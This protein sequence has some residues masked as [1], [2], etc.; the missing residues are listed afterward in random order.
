MKKKI[1]K[2]T[3]FA[4]TRTRLQ[5][6][7]PL[8]EKAVTSHKSERLF[9]ESRDNREDRATRQWKTSYGLTQRTGTKI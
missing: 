8:I 6:A 3:V 2:N 7:T 4:K 5:Q 1:K 9:S